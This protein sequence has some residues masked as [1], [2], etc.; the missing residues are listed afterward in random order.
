M[1]KLFIYF[2]MAMFATSAIAQVDRSKMP[3]PGPAP[4]IKL[5]NAESFTLNNGLK[6]FVVQNSKLP[7]VSYTLIIDRDP[8]LEG[9]KAGMLS[10]VGDMLTAGTSNRP[11]D[12]FNE[13]VDFLGAR[14]SGSSTSLSAS[15]LTKNQE[16]VLELM[17][18]VLYNAVFPEEELEK[19][20]T[21]VK[22]SLALQKN[23]PNGISNTLTTKLAYGTDHPYGE[24][25]TEK[26]VDNVTVEDIK[27]YVNTF[28][29]PNI[30]YLAIVGDVD[31]ET[32]KTLVDKHFS[33][34]EKAEVPTFEYAMPQPP[35]ENVV[36]LVDR[37]SSQQSVINVTYPIENNLASE[38]YLANRIVGFVLGG[39][40]SSRLFV[41][42]R[43]DKSW[44]Y[45]AN[46]S[47]GQDELV[48]TFSA[49][50]SVRGSA[51]DSAVNEFIYEIRNLRDN[52]ITEEEL[53]SAKANLSGA[54]GRSLESPST[55]ANFFLNIEIY[56]LPQDYYTTYLQRLN[57]LTVDQ[58]NAAAKRILKP[59]NMYITV[60]G[61]G[62]EVQE[63][64]MAFGEV[65]RFNNTGEPEVTVAVDES[66]TP[67]AVIQAYLSAIGGAEKVKSIKTSKM[68]SVAEVQ[69]MK[70]EMSYV[71]DEQNQA[72]S[73]KVSM[74]GNVASHTLIKDGKATVTAMGQSQEL[75]DEQFE[76]A[77]MNMFIFPELHYELMGYTL[78]LDGI[79]EIEG[80][81]AYKLVVSN[82]TGASTIN[83]YSVESGLKLKSESADTGE[84]I[85][86]EYEEVEGIKYPMM[87]TLKS[88]MIPMPLEAKVGKIEFNVPISEDD[89]K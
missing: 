78:E 34:W 54:F 16:K 52:G 21:M 35:A 2:I 39:G 26:T 84:M 67:E 56:N 69:G 82:P 65:Q 25:R 33:K 53:A 66:I 70:L 42:L 41:N 55:I 88:P 76:A 46:A 59:E 44:T 23:D 83:Y 85:F 14:I 86:D 63:G 37:S 19:L 8:V 80:E 50:S 15:T 45:G 68:E 1:K 74:M 6:V 29:R 32:A 4:E 18:D 58:V 62:S 61:N 10:F 51:T 64:L 3:E 28:F 71:Y 24:V 31:L 38:D 72:F 89:M 20:K 30:A 13:E 5:G 57:A 75:S 22:S 12:E 79:R 36:A 47:I 40:A 48:A 11:K 49:F 81:E 27:Q 87:M 43:E 60:V 73:N 77:K 17:A 7:R 9:D